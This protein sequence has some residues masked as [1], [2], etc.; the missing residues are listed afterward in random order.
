LCEDKGLDDLRL[1]AAGELHVVKGKSLP[2]TDGALLQ[3]SAQPGRCVMRFSVTNQVTDKGDFMLKRRIIKS[4]F[5]LRYGFINEC[6][7]SW[8]KS[9]FHPCSVI[10]KP[11][12]STEFLYHF[13][14]YI[15]IAISATD[16]SLPSRMSC[17]PPFE[18]HGSNIQVPVDSYSIQR[19]ADLVAGATQSRLA[20][21]D[22]SDLP[23]TEEDHLSPTAPLTICTLGL[24]E[25][26]CLTPHRTN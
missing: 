20:D 11:L 15:R 3:R 18:G 6:W 2:R 16:P 8:E 21:T 7:Q 22:A 26:E 10:V 23:A 24:W 14:P 4:C 9:S 25:K 19:F 17:Y 1:A 5:T 12:Q 13:S